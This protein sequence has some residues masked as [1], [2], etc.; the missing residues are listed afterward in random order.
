MLLLL[1]LLNVLLRLAVPLLLLLL[2]LLLVPL[3]LVHLHC[4]HLC[5]QPCPAIL[6]HGRHRQQVTLCIACAAEDAMA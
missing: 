2:L 6:Q 1:L 3:W 4:C 5:F